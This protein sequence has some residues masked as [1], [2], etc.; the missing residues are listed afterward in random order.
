MDSPLQ[1]CNWPELP[2]VF[3]RT[4]R[5]AVSFVLDHFSVA[6][7]VVSS[8]IIRGNPDPSNDLEIYV[9]SHL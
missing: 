3:D 9:T 7:I 1:V 2:D 4:L 8:T 5:E 6:G